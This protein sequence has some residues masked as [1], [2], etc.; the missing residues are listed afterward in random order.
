MIE[1]VLFVSAMLA[2]AVLTGLVR[3]HA[4]QQ[5][6]LDIPNARSSHTQPTPRGGGVA[7]AGVILVTVVL[8]GLLE[9]VPSGTAIGFVLGGVLIAAIGYYD[10]RKGLSA[11][12]RIAVHLLAATLAVGAL[13]HFGDGAR[14]LPLL[15]GALAFALFIIGVVWSTNLFNFMDGIDGIAGSQAAFVSLASAALVS[16]AHGTSSP[17]LILPVVTGGACVGFLVWNWPPAKIFMGDAGSG[18]LGFWLACMA[19]ALDSIG[20]LSIWTST[21]LGSLFIADATVTLLRRAVRG[22]RWYEAHRSHAYQ[23]LARRW[24]SHLGV[25]GLVCC[26]NL[27]LVLPLAV[28]SVLVPN[29]AVEIATA[30]VA[31]FG[32]LV[33]RAGAGRGEASATL[34][35]R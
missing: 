12:V 30:T 6:I 18:F 20:L 3:R 7:I 9:W 23:V 27:F 1:L 11:R 5:G 24:N 32:L 13:L 17:W 14:P 22:E 21:I 4:M 16:L 19:L 8:S 2:C 35:A 25:T 15:P 34:H 28:A 31:T 33:F 10:D 29:F 26:V